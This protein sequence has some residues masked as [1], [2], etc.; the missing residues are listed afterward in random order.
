MKR[1]KKILA[2]GVLAALAVCILYIVLGRRTYGSVEELR[3]YSREGSD[4]YDYAEFSG[5]I[6]RYSRDGI[7]YLDHENEELWNQPDQMQDPEINVNEEAFVVADIGGNSLMIFT[8][9]GLKGEIS[10]TLPIEKA[11]ISDQGIVT[12]ILK[13]EGVPKI[14]T[15]DT[16]GNILV[17]QQSTMQG[18]G[19]PVSAALSDDCLLYTSFPQPRVYRGSDGT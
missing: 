2:A 4:H 7:V 16:A 14:V 19:Y 9:E 6:V 13:S 8:E 10:T 11:A 1:K 3:D 12:V 15:Y 5:G 18:T 17:E